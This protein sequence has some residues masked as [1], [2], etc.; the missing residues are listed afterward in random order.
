MNI[1]ISTIKQWIDENPDASLWWLTWM[2]TWR[3]IVLQLAFTATLV[4]GVVILAMVA[5][6]FSVLAG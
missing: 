1:Q 3:Q 4:V 5:G 6:F 2:I